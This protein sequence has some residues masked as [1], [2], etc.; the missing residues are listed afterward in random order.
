[1]TH[2]VQSAPVIY[3]GTLLLTHK[4]P[5]ARDS[6][7]FRFRVARVVPL[8]GEILNQS[9]LPFL[10][11]Q[12]LS[13][14]FKGTAWRAYSIASLP[15]EEEIELI[16]RFVE[17]GVASGVLQKSE[18]GDTFPFKGPFGHFLLN[19]NSNA[20]LVFCATGTGIAPLR[21]MIKAEAQ[22]TSPRPMTLLYGGRTPEDIA[23][24]DEL[25][26]WAKNLQ[27]RLA[28]SRMDEADPLPKNAIRGRITQFLET[29]NFSEQTEFYICGNGDMVQSVETL[30]KDKNTP[31]SH[32]F[33]ERFN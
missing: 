11:G 30:L 13:L 12:F 27:I 25:E 16:I 32:I 10:P 21:S 23:Y 15:K 17:G 29:E 18:V 24:L 20:H 14:Q 1:M 28:F 33:R 31:S 7:Q 4:E 8:A 3:G 19:E 22:K 6:C 2:Q 26:T 5:V 9:N